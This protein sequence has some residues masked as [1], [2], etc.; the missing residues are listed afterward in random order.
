MNISMTK[1]EQKKHARCYQLQDLLEPLYVFSSKL[2][3]LQLSYMSLQ[4]LISEIDLVMKTYSL[5]IFGDEY[6][7]MQFERSILEIFSSIF[8]IRDCLKESKI[9]KLDQD[10]TI[11]DIHSSK[12]NL[13]KKHTEILNETLKL[14]DNLRIVKFTYKCRNKL[15]HESLQD[16]KFMTYFFS[17]KYGYDAHQFIMGCDFYHLMELTGLNDTN[18]E[19]NY[20]ALKEYFLDDHIALLQKGIINLEGEDFGHVQYVLK[21]L[22]KYDY[23]DNYQKC[24][25]EYTPSTLCL[26]R[27]TNFENQIRHSNS[28]S[29]TFQD[30]LLKDVEYIFYSYQDYITERQKNK[31]LRDHIFRFNM[32]KFI[33]DSYNIHLSY[34]LK[35]HSLLKLDYFNSM[36]AEHEKLQRDIGITEHNINEGKKRYSAELPKSLYE[37][38]IN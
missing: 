13:G 38:K 24:L 14:D 26:S 6:Y 2:K 28:C 4:Q 5:E 32:Q 34:Y 25:Q 19:F 21:Q 31:N 16:T 3:Q 23:L 36:L 12:S 11:I 27:L 22:D 20:E 17:S 15:I 37:I 7:V 9:I 8:S 35:L 29:E 33:K 18:K 10:K 30:K 1:E